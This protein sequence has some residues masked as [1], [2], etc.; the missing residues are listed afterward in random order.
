LKKGM[1]IILSVAFLN[2]FWSFRSN[3]T[4]YQN[5]WFL[6]LTKDYVS[7]LYY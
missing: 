6:T 4:N 5:A 7:R 1:E 3:F 2:I